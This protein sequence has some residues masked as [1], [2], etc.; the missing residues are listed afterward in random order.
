MKLR[1]MVQFQQAQIVQNTRATGIQK[2]W[3]TVKQD[4]G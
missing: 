3:S 2:N 4:F 1:K